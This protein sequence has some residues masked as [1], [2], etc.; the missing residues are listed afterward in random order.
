MAGLDG[1]AGAIVPLVHTAGIVGHMTTATNFIEAVAFAFSVVEAF[2]E[3][4]RGVEMG[5]GAG[6]VYALE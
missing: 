6:V 4:P 5:G 1:E 3:Q 2:H